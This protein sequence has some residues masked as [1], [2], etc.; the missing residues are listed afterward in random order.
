MM[1]LGSIRLCIALLCLCAGCATPSQDMELEDIVGVWRMELA[2]KVWGPWMFLNE[3]GTFAFTNVP[4]PDENLIADEY[5]VK[6][7]YE[8]EGSK[9]ILHHDEDARPCPGGVVSLEI[10]ITEDGK[11]QGSNWQGDCE[12]DFPGPIYTFQRVGT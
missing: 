9:I 1:R 5:S 7:R 2:E 10:E 12:P 6:G 8:L 4:N 3:N 11:I